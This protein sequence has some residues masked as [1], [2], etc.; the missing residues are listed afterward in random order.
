MPLPATPAW[1]A[2]V[3]NVE[4]FAHGTMS[5]ICFAPRGRDHQT[6]HEQDEIY[7]VVGGSG[8]LVIEDECAAFATGDVLFVAA[9][10]THRFVDFS[11]DPATWALS[12]GPKGGER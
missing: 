2:G 9:G 7:V 8:I 10:R 5:P 3:W 11:D 4:A 12:W 1:P 6:P